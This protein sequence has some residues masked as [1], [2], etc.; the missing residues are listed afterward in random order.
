METIMFILCYYYVTMFKSYYVVWKQ[1]KTTMKNTKAVEFKS[2]YVVWKPHIGA[3]LIGQ[4]NTGLN[5]TMQYGNQ[6][7]SS[8]IQSYNTV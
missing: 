8:A 5:R 6:A 7:I 3:S 1:I 4:R 2:Y